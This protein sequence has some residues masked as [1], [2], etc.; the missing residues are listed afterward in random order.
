MVGRARWILPMTLTATLVAVPPLAGSQARSPVIQLLLSSRDVR[1]R[2]QAAA[3]LGRL[4]PPGAREA[5]ESALSDE[6]AA[7][8]AAAVEALLTLGDAAA[9]AAL[10][11]HVGDRDPGV[12]AGI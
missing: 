2:V 5:L 1:T 4:R 8:R 9:L 3:T 11:R 10:R 12:R 7:V 6:N